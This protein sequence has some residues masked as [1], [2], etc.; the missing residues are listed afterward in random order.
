MYFGQANKDS[1]N[2]QTLFMSARLST[3]RIDLQPRHC[4][5]EINVCSPHFH[6]WI[7]KI[8][9]SRKEAVVWRKAAGLQG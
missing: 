7:T 4:P 6:N 5:A 2:I 1:I 9:Q 8:L 3:E